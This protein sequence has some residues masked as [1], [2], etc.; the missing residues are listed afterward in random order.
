MPGQAV[1][2][3]L[4]SPG[5]EGGALLL[6]KRQQ[7][8][9]SVGFKQHGFLLLVEVEVHQRQPELGQALLRAHEVPIDLELG[10][11][12]LALGLGDAVHIAPEGFDFFELLKVRGKAVGPPAHHQ[13]VVAAAERDFGAVAWRAAGGHQLVAGHT[14][15]RAG[16][17]GKAQVEVAT[18]GREFAQRAHG[19]GVGQIVGGGHGRPH[20]SA[21][22]TWGCAHGYRMASWAAGGLVDVQPLPSGQLLH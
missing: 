15:L 9:G 12:E 2:R 10:P 6:K 11:V 4:L 16:A 17:G 8:L 14:F 21:W 1:S 20:G 18:P 5:H 13:A 7:R 19:H 22:L 3:L